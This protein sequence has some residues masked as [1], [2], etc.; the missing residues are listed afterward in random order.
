MICRNRGLRCHPRPAEQ[1]IGASWTS[2]FPHYLEELF[3]PPFLNQ[4]SL[5]GCSHGATWF[6]HVG[7]VP[8][9][10]FDCLLL[11]VPESHCAEP[12]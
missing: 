11:Q 2:S 4:A 7:A 9:A 12:R 10:A 8:E 5:D 3:V 1:G 6:V